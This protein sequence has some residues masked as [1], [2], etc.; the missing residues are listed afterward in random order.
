[1]NIEYPWKLEDQ[2]YDIFVL[3]ALNGP[4]GDEIR[5]I[6][7]QNIRASSFLTDLFIDFFNSHFTV[8]NFDYIVYVPS[9]KNTDLM[10]SLAEN[11]GEKL[12]IPVKTIV[13]FQKTVQEQKHI[14]SYQV[15]Y[16][17]IKNAF[18]FSEIPLPEDK[19]LLIDDVYASGATLKEILEMFYLKECTSIVSVIFAYRQ[20]TQDI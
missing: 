1:M 16:K 7:Q 2:K 18:S 12:L 20:M 4:V 13:Q 15:R 10:K 8:D 17:N 19:V 9:N 14:E 3:G 5:N 11:I 6:K